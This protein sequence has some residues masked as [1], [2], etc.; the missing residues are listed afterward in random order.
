MVTDQEIVYHRT[1]LS[2]EYLDIWRRKGK[3]RLQA[4]TSCKD[5][6]GLS[7]KCGREMSFNK[8]AWLTS[9]RSNAST[10]LS[11]SEGSHRG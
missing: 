2:P 11:T 10:I 4:W 6:S 7:M 9:G 1:F 5:Y 3:Q 8:M